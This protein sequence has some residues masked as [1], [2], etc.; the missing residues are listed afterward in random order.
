MQS[1]TISSNT[2]GLLLT[3]LSAAAAAAFFLLFQDA[4]RGTTPL[5]SVYA[6]FVF[7]FL[8]SLPTNAY[9]LKRLKNV[10]W[11]GMHFILL[12]L[13]ALCT[14]VGNVGI[15]KTLEFL[16][17]SEAHLIQRS[18]T[19]FSILIGILILREG[20]GWI[21]FFSSLLFSLGVYNLYLSTTSGA[22]TIDSIF[23]FLTALLSA[24]SFAVM[25]TAS[26]LLMSTINAHLINIIRLFVAI[27]SMSILH[28]LVIEG[29]ISLPYHALQNFAIAAFVGPFMARI[30]YMYA[31]YLIGI[32]RTAL[33]TSTSP[34]YTLFLQIAILG[35]ALNAQQIIGSILLL[36]AVSL[37]AAYA[38]IL[39]R[40][41]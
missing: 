33:F 6:L 5:I 16:P 8:F 34:V 27:M 41:P 3:Q 18:E 24:L 21:L 36:L 38:F 14:F 2:K 29:F 28:P 19:I 39:K 22:M 26:K 13:I 1:I 37:P 15:V 25:Q 31:G 4:S 11:R 40:F 10:Q 23:P 7:A 20:G 35:Y 17:P 9:Y 32:S 12:A 30:A